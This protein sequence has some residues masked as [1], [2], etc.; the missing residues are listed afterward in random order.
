MSIP[1]GVTDCT[2]FLVCPSLVMRRQTIIFNDSHASSYL[3]PLGYL[4]QEIYIPLS[5]LSCPFLTVLRD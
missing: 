2:Y 4:V 3:H 5:P 1:E